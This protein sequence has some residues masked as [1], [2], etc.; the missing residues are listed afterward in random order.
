MARTLPIPAG[1]P[2]DV[3]R[4]AA[5]QVAALADAQAAAVQAAASLTLAALV[6]PLIPAAGAVAGLAGALGQ[7]RPLRPLPDQQVLVMPGPGVGE[8]P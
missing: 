8:G 7:R 3:T 6:W 5:G 1:Q 2:L 4:T